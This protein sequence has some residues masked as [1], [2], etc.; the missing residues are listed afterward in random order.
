MSIIHYYDPTPYFWVFLCLPS[1]NFMHLILQ[2]RDSNSFLHILLYLLS[3][4][5]RLKVMLKQVRGQRW[6]Q[7]ANKKLQFAFFEVF[8]S[9]KLSLLPL[10]STLCLWGWPQY[11]SM[12]SLYSSALG[13]LRSVKSPEVGLENVIKQK[14][15]K[16]KSNIEGES[17]L[18][19]W[20]C[21]HEEDSAAGGDKNGC[22]RWKLFSHYRHFCCCNFFYGYGLIGL[23]GFYV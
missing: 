6:M 19:E 13:G 16:F 18:H 11:Q 23:E 3:P 21:P 2:I 22:R 4:E 15:G 12:K 10:M 9:M 20:E 5:T 17:Y 8:V 14:V 7:R 1:I